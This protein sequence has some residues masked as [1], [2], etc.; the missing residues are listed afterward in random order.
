MT[1]EHGSPISERLRHEITSPATAKRR[2]RWFLLVSLVAFVGFLSLLLRVRANPRIERDIVTTLR[3]Q[4]V[5]HP[6]LTR[7]MSAVSW[8]GFRPQS[9]ALPATAV[10][11]TWVIGLRRESRYLCFAWVVSMLSYT[12][13]RF[14]NRPRPFGEG[15]LVTKAS[16]RDS[17]FP[18]GHTLHYVSFW[19]FF[20]YVCFTR[21]RGRGERWAPVAFAGWLI[22]SVGPSRIYLGHHWLT[23]VLAS[24]CLGIGYLTTLI[25]LHRRTLVDGLTRS[26][27]R[28]A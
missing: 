7:M 23:D 4:R 10:A 6:L 17:S 13:K 18:S 25:G 26:R 24:Y 28:G 2:G 9:L 14:V 21:L 11:G 5:T 12:T 27:K 1:H 16:L 22:G 19:G 3:M 8:F 15:I 20:A